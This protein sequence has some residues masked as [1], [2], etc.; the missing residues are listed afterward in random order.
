MLQ[1]VSRIASPYKTNLLLSD[2]PNPRRQR[3][4][5]HNP[6]RYTYSDHDSHKL[7]RVKVMPVEQCKTGRQ[8]AMPVVIYL[9]SLAY[10]CSPLWATQAP[11]E[12]SSLVQWNSKPTASLIIWTLVAATQPILQI[13]VHLRD[14]DPP[15]THV[16]QAIYKNNIISLCTT[17]PHADDLRLPTKQVQ[18]AIWRHWLVRW[19]R[20]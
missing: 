17:L 5:A 8:S 1:T 4:P 9:A 14:C 3:C 13:L 20:E 2:S 18:I 15:F 10:S 16:P 19:A 6:P 11:D 12:I 7:R